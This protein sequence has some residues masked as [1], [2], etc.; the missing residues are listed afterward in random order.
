MFTRMYCHGHPDP[1]CHYDRFITF[2]LGHTDGI[3]TIAKVFAVWNPPREIAE[4]SAERIRLV[5]NGEKKID[6]LFSDMTLAQQAEMLG[7][8]GMFPGQTHFH[9]T[10]LSTPIPGEYEEVQEIK[11]EWI[12]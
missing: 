3:D 11:L 7:H 5:Q 2:N 12:K 1:I 8:L 10:V 9:V 4:I 6:K